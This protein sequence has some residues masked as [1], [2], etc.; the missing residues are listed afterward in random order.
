MLGLER[1][2]PGV[3]TPHGVTG[4]NISRHTKGD[5]GVLIAR[6]GD[7]AGFADAV[8][9]FVGDSALWH[10]AS[11]GAKEH[12]HTQFSGEALQQDLEALLRR[13]ALHRSQRWHW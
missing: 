5:E 7:P 11:Q 13:A 9:A 3:T 1:G 8:A 2:L 12:A 6:D 10:R 4:Y